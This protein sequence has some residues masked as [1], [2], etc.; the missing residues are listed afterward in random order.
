[1]AAFR[2]LIRTY[3]LFPEG[4]RDQCGMHV[5]RHAIFGFSFTPPR[6]RMGSKGQT[7]PRLGSNSQVCHPRL[8]ADKKIQETKGLM[9]H[10]Q[11]SQKS[12]EG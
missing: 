2:R 7:R 1:M 9:S 4:P 5:G 8:W 3:G 11:G 12:A 6:G 10:L